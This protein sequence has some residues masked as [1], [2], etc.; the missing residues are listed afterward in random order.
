MHR[1]PI[2]AIVVG[3]SFPSLGSAENLKVQPRRE[4]TGVVMPE[5]SV[6]LAAKIMG[7]IDAV[8]FDEGD[9]VG[10]NDLLISLD[11]AELRAEL[12]H[13]QAALGLAQAELEHARKEEARIRKLYRSKSLSRD[14]FDDAALEHTAAGER[15]KMAEATLAQTQARLD[16]TLIK[17][18]FAGVITRKEA[19]LGQLT[20]PGA[21]LLVLEDH[22]QLKLRTRVKE[23]DIPYISPG[24]SVSVTIDALDGL[25]LEGKVSKIIPSGDVTTH[26]FVVEAVLPSR[27]KLYPGMFGKADFSR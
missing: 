10:V 9:T 27:E 22:K 8:H 2:F 23:Q 26:A 20:R 7:R 18:P 11:N 17:A 4:S 3:L 16:E 5:R 13:A 15:L 14:E 12:A 24:Q 1:L 19:E 6:A 25:K 21:T